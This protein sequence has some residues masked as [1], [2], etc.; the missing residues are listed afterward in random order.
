MWGTAYV[1]GPFDYKM[2]M[3]GTQELKESHTYACGC[4]YIPDLQLV[5]SVLIMS[6]LVGFL[7]TTQCLYMIHLKIYSYIPT[8]FSGCDKFR[9]TLVPLVSSILH[10]YTPSSSESTLHS[11]WVKEVPEHSVWEATTASLW[12]HFREETEVELENKEIKSWYI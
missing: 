5:W 9:S 1:R 12:S 8:T 2:P 3:G 7:C 10:V 6:A 11:W 4:L